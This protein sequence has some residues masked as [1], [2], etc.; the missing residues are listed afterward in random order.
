VQPG[1]RVVI[2]TRK[3]QRMVDGSGS[4][5]EFAERLV[6]GA[7]GHLLGGVGE[8]L[9]RAEVIGVDEVGLPGGEQGEGQIVEI[10]I[11]AQR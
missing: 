5:H 7:P 1:F 11:F 6:V 3:A 10:D 8:Y 9:R 4:P 2:L